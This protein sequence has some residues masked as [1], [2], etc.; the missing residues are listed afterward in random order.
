MFAT[1]TQHLLQKQLRGRCAVTLGDHISAH[2]QHPSCSRFGLSTSS[3]HLTICASCQHLIM[4][5]RRAA[6]KS[7]QLNGQ[8]RI[9]RLSVA[10][11]AP[12]I[13][14]WRSYAQCSSRRGPLVSQ[15]CSSWAS[16][17]RQCGR[18]WS[19]RRSRH[20]PRLLWEGG[21]PPAPSHTSR[22]LSRCR[23][24]AGGTRTFLICRCL[25]RKRC[26]RAAGGT[27]T[28]RTPGDHIRTLPNMD[29]P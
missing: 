13:R 23:R 11:V 29:T 1:F 7:M 27:R 15:T 20:Q 24:A 19:R 9:G 18:R 22:I 4:V 10:R 2:W 8:P 6:E 26:R 12:A 16:T 25:I 14:R 21:R 3:L 28:Q 17:R 5:T